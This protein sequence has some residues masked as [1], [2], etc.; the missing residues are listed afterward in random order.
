MVTSLTQTNYYCNNSLQHMYLLYQT[1]MYICF[2]SYYLFIIYLHCCQLLLNK[3]YR[4]I[5]IPMI[6]LWC[7]AFSNHGGLYHA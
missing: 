2:D 1:F 4:E 6:A 3:I 7:P 5:S